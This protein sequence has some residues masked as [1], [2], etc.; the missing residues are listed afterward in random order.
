[1]GSGPNSSFVLPWVGLA[2]KIGHGSSCWGT[3][4]WHAGRVLQQLVSVRRIFV[5]R[6]RF[7]SSTVWVTHVFIVVFHWSCFGY[8]L[9]GQ[10]KI[11]QSVPLSHLILILREQDYETLQ[12]GIWR[13]NPTCLYHAHRAQRLRDTHTFQTM[14]HNKAIGAIS[15][16]P[17]QKCPVS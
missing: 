1:M 12:T 15:K 14:W 7:F 4:W 3:M 10:I 11:E 17:P 5:Y 8:Y 9:I 2:P 6:E 13:R 16:C